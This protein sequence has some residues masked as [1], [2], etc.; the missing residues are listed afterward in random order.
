MRK[1]EGVTVRATG[2][3]AGNGAG[4]AGSAQAALALIVD[5][6]TASSATVGVTTGQCGNE[7]LAGNGADGAVAASSL[8]AKTAGPGLSLSSSTQGGHGGAGR[9]VGNRGGAGA[10]AQATLSASA[11]SGSLRTNI[12]L[13]GGNGDS[14]Y[15]GADGGDGAAM[16]HTATP[17][18]STSGDVHH[19]VNVFGG[20]AG[21]SSGG[22]AANAGLQ[23]LSAPHSRWTGRADSVS[24]MR[25]AS[26]LCLNHK[27]G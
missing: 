2:G 17:A 19:T 4:T 7:F 5:E 20:S 23:D 24:N 3:R 15:S 27:P 26:R 16:R 1:A 25:S 18:I 6:R 13:G 22:M 14:G 11:G 8:S 21:Y 10:A 9:G 12:W